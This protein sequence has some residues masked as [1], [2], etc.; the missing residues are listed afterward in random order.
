MNTYNFPVE[1]LILCSFE[2]RVF[3]RLRGEA[4]CMNT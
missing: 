3:G 1:Y 2:I 4:G